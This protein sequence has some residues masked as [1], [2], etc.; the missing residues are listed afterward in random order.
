[1]KFKNVYKSAE[2]GPHHCPC[3]HCLT[4]SER[5][6]FEI[7]PVCFWEDDG[8]D[9]HDANEV[10]GGPNGKLSLSGA[11]SNYR[12][13]AACEKS[14]LQHVRPPTTSERAST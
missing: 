11:R 10:R 8:Q 7:C 3:C 13:F 6:G 9:D 4:L 2:E 12:T 5:G 14:A 1:M